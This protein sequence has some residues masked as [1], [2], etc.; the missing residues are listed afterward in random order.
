[1]VE[2]KTGNGWKIRKRALAENSGRKV[3]RDGWCRRRFICRNHRL[4][5]G[6][7]WWRG[8]FSDRH[9]PSWQPFLLLLFFSGG[10]NFRVAVLINRSIG[11]E[12]LT[13]RSGKHR[14][15]SGRYGATPLLGNKEWVPVYHHIDRPLL[16]SARNRQDWFASHRPQVQLL[17]SSVAAFTDLE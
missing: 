17:H 3:R 12:R 13:D 5:S 14:T 2:K 10:V 15:S 8:L 16:F 9:A 1:M 7:N 4:N 11:V 6:P